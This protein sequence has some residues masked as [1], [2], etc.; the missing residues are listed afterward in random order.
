M[1]A[2]FST[3]FGVVRGGGVT[4]HPEATA[5]SSAAAAT[6]AQRRIAAG[7]MLATPPS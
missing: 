7:I 4:L 1:S 3:G 5:I 2:D 6:A